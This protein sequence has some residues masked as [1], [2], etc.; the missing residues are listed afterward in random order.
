VPL[1]RDVV[2]RGAAKDL[3]VGVD[4]PQAAGYMERGTAGEDVSAVPDQILR[5]LILPEDDGSRRAVASGV[6]WT[7]EQRDAT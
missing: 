3:V 2:I 7:K 4:P 1:A 6:V 5:S